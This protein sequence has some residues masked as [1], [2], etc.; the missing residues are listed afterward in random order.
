MATRRKLRN[1]STPPT[2][3]AS[4]EGEE[5]MRLYA[6][7]LGRKIDALNE[8]IGLLQAAFAERKRLLCEID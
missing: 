2:R 6:A 7:E 3:D 5:A 4:L 8:Q 1:K